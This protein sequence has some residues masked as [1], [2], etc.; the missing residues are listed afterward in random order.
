M[1]GPC[2]I[3]IFANSPAHPRKAGSLNL[4]MPHIGVISCS[5]VV[6]KL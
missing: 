5:F 6:Q 3:Y 4:F 1:Q 2:Q